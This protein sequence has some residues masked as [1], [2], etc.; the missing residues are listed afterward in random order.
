LVPASVTVAS[1]AALLCW[2]VGR[3]TSPAPDLVATAGTVHATS[4]P[5][6]VYGVGPHR[7]EVVAGTAVRFD[8]VDR[9]VALELTGGQITC[10]VAPLTAGET[11]RVRA[12]HAEAQV[13]GTRFL[14]AVT[15]ECTTVTVLAGSV[16]MRAVSAPETEHHLD[17][18]ERRVACAQRDTEGNDDTRGRAWVHEAMVLI[19]RDTEHEHA[20]A[21]LE[22]YLDT[23]PGELFEEEAL[24]HLCRLERSLG[25]TARADELAAR[26]F[27]SFPGSRRAR[28]L[29]ALPRSAPTPAPGHGAPSP[30]P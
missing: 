1:A 5:A 30:A 17:T 28:E 26:F 21:L 4:D 12:P 23:Y 24:F 19:G 7:V 15:G 9:E 22:R 8:A 16:S 13:K 18:G 14:V 11:F 2:V 3:P 27:A 10:A 29:R 25:H 6:R 20:A